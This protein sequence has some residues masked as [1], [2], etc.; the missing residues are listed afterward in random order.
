M[1]KDTF[2]SEDE[3]FEAYRIVAEELKG[4]SVTI[5]TM[6]IGGDKSLPY[7]ELPK[8]ENPFLGW[9]AIRVCLDREKILKTQFRVKN[10]Y[11]LV[12]FVIVRIVLVTEADAH[13]R[14]FKLE[15]LAEKF[16]EVLLIARRHIAGT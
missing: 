3:Q 7:M 4:Y 12:L 16:G 2:P 14:T 13:R 11:F 10:H 1:E 8:E 15:V 9:R 6:D 5:R